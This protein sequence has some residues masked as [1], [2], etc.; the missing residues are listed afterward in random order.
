MSATVDAANRMAVAMNAA[1][2]GKVGVVSKPG[3]S[4]W[5]TLAFEAYRIPGVTKVANAVINA[6]NQVQGVND[7][8]VSGVKG[9]ASTTV[10]TA[11]AAVTGLKLGLEFGP[12]LIVLFLAFYFL[13]PI[14]F[15]PRR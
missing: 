1:P 8:V 11:K 4:I 14:L 12:L 7:A 3:V 15:A 9:A 6:G 5:D 13:Y 2:Q 10:D